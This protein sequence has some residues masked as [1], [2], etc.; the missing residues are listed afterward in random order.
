M[1]PSALGF[2]I[3]RGELDNILPGSLLTFNAVEGYFWAVTFCSAFPLV[4]NSCVHSQKRLAILFLFFNITCIFPFC[5]GDY[6]VVFVE[7][8]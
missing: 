1:K 4:V 7:K 8:V 6:L 2:V 3:G 5:G